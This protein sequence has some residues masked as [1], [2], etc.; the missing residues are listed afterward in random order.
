M[1][2][3]KLIQEEINAIQLFENPQIVSQ[4]KQWLDDCWEKVSGNMKIKEVIYF[5]SKNLDDDN[6]FKNS[7]RSSN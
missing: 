6:R 1:N 3:E 4:K 5:N 2:V 7:C